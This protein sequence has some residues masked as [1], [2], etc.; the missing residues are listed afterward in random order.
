MGKVFAEGLGALGAK[1]DVCNIIA[2]R[3]EGTT[4]G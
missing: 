2:E 1:V 3:A 4:S